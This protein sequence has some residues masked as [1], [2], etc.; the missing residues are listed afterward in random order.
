MIVF[1]FSAFSTVV[2][3]PFILFDYHPM[4]WYQWASLLMAGIAAMGGQ[5]NITAAYTYAPAKEISVFDYSQ[6]IF[7]AILGFFFFDQ[8]P[9]LLSLVGYVL[10]VGAAVGRW[11]YRDRNE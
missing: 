8:V 2:T 11:W 5:L 7:A 1:F 4:E 10:I 3:A 6:L 9:D